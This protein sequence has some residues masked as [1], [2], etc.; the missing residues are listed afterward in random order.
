M[1]FI[2]WFALIGLCLVAVM[3]V[4]TAVL[5][6]GASVSLDREYTHTKQVAALP[7]L[8][9]NSTT[10]LVRIQANGY[11]FRA[12][13]AGLERTA[14][15]APTIVL[16]HG[17][18]VTSAM[19]ETLMPPLA[20]AGYRVIAFDQRGYSPGARPKNP[21]QYRTS[22]LVS[23]VLAVAQAVGAERFHLIGHD[24][25]SVVGWNTVM[26]H[27]QQVISWVGLS[28]AH[29]VAFMDAVQNDPDQRGKSGY[30]D[31][32]TAP[33]LPEALFA[34]ND[35]SFLM[36]AYQD[37]TPSQQQ[38]YRRVF[39]EPGALTA[40]LNWYRQ[41]GAAI[42]EQANVEIEIDTPTLFIWGNR[43]PYAGRAAVENQI[44]YMRGPYRK[45]EIDAG[46][47]LLEK[48]LA[49]VLPAIVQH[50]SDYSGD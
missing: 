47:W 1:K 6:I 13:I 24:W 11:E 17:F 48:N 22:L 38:E 43:D 8:S 39:A 46:H 32:F 19:W 37:M 33:Y 23:D 35:F 9:N 50:L 40:A 20:Q 15:Q 45:L 31:L 12:R 2:K 21:K 16:L 14:Q 36:D 10:G 5:G 4:I 27:P 25:G 41:M 7:L 29:P 30:F 49:Q 28:I 18:P 42:E 26:S 34:F 3:V 44:N